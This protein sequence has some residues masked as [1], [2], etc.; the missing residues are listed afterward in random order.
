MGALEKLYQQYKDRV[1]FVLVYIREAHPDSILLIPKEGGG[2]ELGVVPQTET[3]DDRLKNL[4]LCA[5]LLQ[6]TMPSVIDTRDNIVNRAYAAWP[7]RLY[8]IGIDGKV[9]FKSGP[10]P[11]GFKSPDLAAWLQKNIP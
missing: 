4:R 5:S 2:T 11:S 9:A 1:Q 10:G 8:A 6:F 3:E 7:D